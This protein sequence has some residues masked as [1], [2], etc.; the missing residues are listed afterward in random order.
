MIVRQLAHHP[1][2]FEAVAVASAVIDSFT[3]STWALP[4]SASPGADD[5]IREGLRAL[6]P[7]TGRRPAD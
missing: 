1:S 4:T 5:P 2:G 6:N 7:H 3:A